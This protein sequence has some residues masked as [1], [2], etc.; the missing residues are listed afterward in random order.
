MMK[1]GQINTVAG[2]VQVDTPLPPNPNPYSFFWMG[3]FPYLN[4]NPD[5]TGNI[6]EYSLGMGILIFPTNVPIVFLWLVKYG[7]W[8]LSYF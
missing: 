7:F 2:M 8:L 3:K 4:P 5:P 1:Y 6:Y